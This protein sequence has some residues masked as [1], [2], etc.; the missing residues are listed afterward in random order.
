MEVV[1]GVINQC[2]FCERVA[3]NMHNNNVLEAWQVFIA[4]AWKLVDLFGGSFLSRCCSFT[5]E[6]ERI[7]VLPEQGFNDQNLKV[8]YCLSEYN[9]YHGCLDCLFFFNSWIWRVLFCESVLCLGLFRGWCEGWW[10][11]HRARSLDLPHH[12]DH[13]SSSYKQKDSGQRDIECPFL[14]SPKITCQPRHGWLTRTSFHFCLWMWCLG[15]C[16]FIHHCRRGWVTFFTYTFRPLPPCT[17]RPLP[18]CSLGWVHHLRPV[19]MMV[20]HFCLAMKPHHHTSEC[21]ENKHIY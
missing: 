18:P 19:N 3:P 14:C 5:F 21:T 1:L 8:W 7:S 11:L 2:C 10:S 20:F 17:F 9:E 6:P 4:G 13:Y 15:R 12:H 16:A